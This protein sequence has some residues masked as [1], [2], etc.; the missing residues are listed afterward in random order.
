[1]S[2]K[3]SKLSQFWE[4]LKRRKVIYV[5]TVYASAAFVIIE[6]V[7]NVFEP[8][9]LPDRTPTYAIIILAI[10]FP[11]AIILSW[12]FDLTPK[13]VEKTKPLTEGQQAGKSVTTNG[14]K[15]AT[16]VSIAVII[17]LIVLNL[18]G[19]TKPLKA[20]DIQSLLIL[21]LPGKPRQPGQ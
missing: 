18:A 16:Y 9:N 11:I 19:E 8:L 2:E 21:P 17:G 1:M 13:G 12:I 4:E 3:P 6:L 10:G 14:W 15:I 20:G 7:N 5:I